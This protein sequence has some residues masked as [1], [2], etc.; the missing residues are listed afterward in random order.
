M[1]EDGDVVLAVAALCGPEFDLAVVQRALT[2]WDDQRRDVASA[3]S[4]AART[5]V[6]EPL[7]RSMTRYRFTDPDSPERLAATLSP[8]ERATAHVR[9][10]RALEQRGGSLV[11]VA[12]HLLAAAPWSDPEGAVAVGTRAAAAAAAR[13][14]ATDAARLYERTLEAA[15]FVDPPDPDRRADLL[16]RLGEAHMACGDRRAALH[17]VTEALDVAA[18]LDPRAGA[19]IAVRAAQ[20]YSSWPSV[21]ELEAA[22]RE[23]ETVL[24]GAVAALGEG[25]SAERAILLA[26]LG[27]A[28]R[29]FPDPRRGAELGA[30]A[31]QVARRVGDDGAMAAALLCRRLLSVDPARHQERLALT[32]RSVELAT[33]TASPDE[34]MSLFLHIDDQV[35]AGDLAGATATSRR[36]A[37]VTD[38]TGPGSRWLASRSRA[39]LVLLAGRTDRAET[40]VLRARDVGLRA[41]HPRAEVSFRTQ[42]SAL[43]AV[44]GQIDEGLADWRAD[45]ENSPWH[46]AVFARVAVGAGELAEGRVAAEDLLALGVDRLT[47]NTSWLSTVV[48]LVDVVS[49]LD[50][51]AAVPGL[52]EA[53]GPYRGQV[54]S[55]FNGLLWEGAVDHWLGVLAAIEGDEAAD[56]HFRDAVVCHDRLGAVLLGAATRSAYATWL[57]RRANPGDA[58]RADALVDQALA[59][60]RSR[61]AHGLEA[62]IAGTGKADGVAPA[63][64]GPSTSL[65]AR[66]REVLA[67]VAGG[68]TNKEIA[69]RLH[70][71]AATVQRHTINLYR[72]IEVSNRSAATAYAA[73]HGLLDM[74]AP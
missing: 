42:R 26:R 8:A 31:E 25:D 62:R 63:G 44:D 61:G 30:A 13:H 2:E 29:L 41:Q 10:G 14:A 33:S 34:A 65:S 15:A 27:Q 69:G 51:D 54:I 17:A 56:Q 22:D 43:R 18:D 45:A 49:V 28:Y 53:L 57:R 3:V 59:A 11:T 68:L 20:V 1:G 39:S 16:V 32:T 46:Q 21:P 5:G 36:L 12:E 72:K 67:L 38:D 64:A 37:A 70:I 7:A 71:S 48:A 58:H 52:R 35:C 23:L 66:E 74:P 40:L 4:E 47:R 50:L 9:L 73:R 19:A 55:T 60:A 6:V 24:H